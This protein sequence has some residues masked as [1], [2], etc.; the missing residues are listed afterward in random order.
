MS[1]YY[2]YSDFLKDKYGA[3]TYKLPVNL[4]YTCPNRDGNLGTGGCHFCGADG[5]AFED[6]GSKSV[7]E[8]LLELKDFIGQK[9]GAHR[10]IAYY[11]NFTNTYLPLEELKENIAPALEIED[12]V[13]VALSTRPDCVSD[14]YL[15]EIKE[16]VERKDCELTVELGLQTANYHTLLSCNRGHTLAEFI[17]AVLTARK[18]DIEVGVHL[19]LNL[20]GETL[21][22]VIENAKIMSALNVNTVKLHNLYIEKNTT[23][24]RLYKKGEIEITAADEYVNRVVTFLAYLAPDIAIQRLVGRAPREKTLFMNWDYNKQEIENMIK[25]HLAREDINQGDRCDYL[26]GKALHK[27]Y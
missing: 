13:E 26:G 22:D 24:A 23:Y 3:K 19:I 16:M 14:R 10:F 1:R 5:A 27:F 9:Y 12:I 17:D 25:E 21:N 18:Y 15:G 7:R 8:Q 20:P 4:D 2:R 11:Q 6:S